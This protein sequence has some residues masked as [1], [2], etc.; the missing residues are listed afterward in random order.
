MNKIDILFKC[1]I[2]LY[3]ESCLGD[4]T[5]DSSKNLVKTIIQQMKAMNNRKPLLGG[6]TDL[7]EELINLCIDMYSGDDSY[8]KLNLIQTLEVILKDNTTLYNTIEKSLSAEIDNPGL[9]RSILALRRNLENYYK[10]VE[11]INIIKK[12][13]Y[14]LS[15]GKPEEGMQ[16]FTSKLIINLEALN[17]RTKTKDPGI[18]DEIDMSDGH[19]LDEI[20]AKVKKQTVE[21]GRLRTGWKELNELLGGGFRKGE[22]VLTSALQH[23][24]KSGFLRSIFAQLCMFNKPQLKNKDKRPLNLFI[25]FE[26]DSDIV[27]EFFYKYLYFSEHNE[28]AV[29]ENV[30]PED[31]TTYLIKNLTRTGYNVK[32]IRVNPSEWT[33]KSVLNKVLEYEA[34]G[35][36]IHVVVLD[37]LSK[38]PTTGCD[39]TGPIGTALRD[40]LTRMR[41][42]MSARNVLF[43]NCH[44]LSTEAKQLIRN[45]VPAKDFVKEI[46]N[47]GYYEGSKQLDQVVDLELHQHI[48]KL[49]KNKFYLTIQRG[50][51]R[52]PE[53][54]PEDKK[55]FIL[56]FP[57]K[58][59]CIP[60][61][62]DFEGKYIGF[63]YSIEDSL[64]I[65][66]TE[67]VI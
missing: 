32:F 45:G 35:Y 63:K 44:Q 40:M 14:Q 41:D 29:I 30:A 46:A 62:I 11:T 58:S 22:T 9:K 52:Y 37:Y 43:L 21:D 31:I 3:R 16:E 26:D 7:T 6:V 1:I 54:I 15:L 64:N 17:S 12:A 67:L 20:F 61:N 8:D 47:K 48:A 34:S 2:L 49:G 65:D 57:V 38:L 28:D 24:F 25:S 59:P 18:V 51:R 55:Y 13:S 42:F 36:E 56:P 60:P 10:E 19:D 23:N 50:K 27:A 39:T 33:Y 53:I 66:N 4:V 5:S